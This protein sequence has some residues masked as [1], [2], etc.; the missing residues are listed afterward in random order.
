M[1]SPNRRGGQ[2]D[3]TNLYTCIY[4]ERGRVEGRGGVGGGGGGT[5]SCAC[6]AQSI[7]AHFA[8]WAQL[9]RA[10]SQCTHRI[11]SIMTYHHYPL[12]VNTPYVSIYTLEKYCA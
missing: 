12:H 5:V 2:D 10:L 11:G 6:E 8:V 1:T 4:T 9:G 7:V 3:I